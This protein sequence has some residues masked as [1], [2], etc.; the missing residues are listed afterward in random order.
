M[1]NNIVGESSSPT[2][3]LLQ[4]RGV[5]L[6]AGAAGAALLAAKTLTGTAPAAPVVAEVAK[7]LAETGSGYQVTPHVLRYYETARS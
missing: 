7:T 1:K 6:G 2:E 3:S 4:R 5:L